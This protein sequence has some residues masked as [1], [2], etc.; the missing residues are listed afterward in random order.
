MTNENARNMNEIL[1]ALAETSGVDAHAL[2][3]AC[4]LYAKVAIAVHAKLS[5]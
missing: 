5:A 2:K 4:E 3:V 1:A